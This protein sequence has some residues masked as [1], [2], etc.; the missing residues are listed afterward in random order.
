[1]I[2]LAGR[3]GVTGQTALNHHYVAV[4]SIPGN[5]SLT[6]RSRNIHIYTTTKKVVNLARL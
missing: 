5:K 1:M 2:N 6:K 3:H 4:L